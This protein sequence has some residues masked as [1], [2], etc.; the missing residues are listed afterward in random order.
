M[1][2]D[3]SRRA[4]TQAR[5][6]LAQTTHVIRVEAVNVFVRRNALEDFDIINAGGKRQLNQDAINSLIGIQRVDKFQ[7]LR[8]AGGFREIVR[9]G[10]EAYLFTR[11]ALAA[12]INLRCRVAA[13]QHDG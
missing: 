2:D 9:A 5:R 4:R 7:Q 11:F 3:P 12:D 13:D 8:F 10:D 6:A 1:R